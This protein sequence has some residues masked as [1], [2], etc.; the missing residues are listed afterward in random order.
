MRFFFRSPPRRRAPTLAGLAPA[1][2]KGATTCLSRSKLPC[3]EQHQ[4]LVAQ[5]FAF[6]FPVSFSSA[7][8]WDLGGTDKECVIA[9]QFTLEEPDKTAN[10]LP[11]KI[12]HR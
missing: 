9:D 8:T 4:P 6:Q 12:A 3:P 2:T 7:A 1:A 5:W 10:E 11:N